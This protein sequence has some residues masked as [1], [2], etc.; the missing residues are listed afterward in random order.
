MPRLTAI[1]IFA[2]VLLILASSRRADAALSLPSIGAACQSSVDHPEPADE[3]SKNRVDLSAVPSLPSQTM[4][5]TGD[6][7]VGGPRV[8]GMFLMGRFVTPPA[9]SFSRF[10]ALDYSLYWPAPP[11]VD[12]LRPPQSA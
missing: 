10:S 1:L 12:L 4:T 9:F 11:V 2:L 8:P 6:G 7:D 5:P 3:E